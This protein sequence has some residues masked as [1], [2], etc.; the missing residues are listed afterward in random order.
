MRGALRGIRRAALVL[1]GAASVVLFPGTAEAQANDGSRQAAIRAFVASDLGRAEELAGQWLAAHPKDAEMHLLLGLVRLTAGLGAE[2]QEQRPRNEIMALYSDA[3]ASL[4]EAER[5]AAGRSLRQLDAAVGS[6]HLARGEHKAA[7]QRFRKA[8]AQAPA[9]AVLHRQRGKALL[10]LDRF[11]DADA[12]LLRAIKLDPDEP[13][14][15]L[16]YAE[17]LFQRGKERSAR[18]SLTAYYERIRTT[19]PDSRHFQVSYEIAR[20][21]ILMNE[22]Q[23]ARTA[24]ERAVG[25]DPGSALARSELGRV[26]FW[27]GEFELAETQFD[28]VLALRGVGSALRADAWHH[29]G[30]IARARGDDVAAALAFEAALRDTPDRAE[31]LQHYGAVLRRLGRES[32]ARTVLDRFGAV[33]TLENQA[34]RLRNLLIVSPRD[35]STRRELVD[36]LLRL[37]QH[38]EAASALAELQRVQPDDPAIPELERRMRDAR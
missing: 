10:G 14:A 4:L 25:I 21:S 5:L 1:A 28:A 30:M 29:E 24:L 15:R 37:G 11:T 18:D 36:L 6:I 8:L 9:D 38:G 13:A 26:A 16:L 35:A 22:L 20:Y 17:S 7:E 27:Q 31:V 34:R 33:A 2:A 3:L 12:E 19:P 23:T 32:E